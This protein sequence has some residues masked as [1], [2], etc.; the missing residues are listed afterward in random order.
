[1]IPVA[2]GDEAADALEAV[3]ARLT[4]LRTPVPHTVDPAWI[5]P[6]RATVE[7]AVPRA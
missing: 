2:F 5:A 4:R 6:L 3:G 7:A 1:V